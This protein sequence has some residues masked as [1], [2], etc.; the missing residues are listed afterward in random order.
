MSVWLFQPVK[1]ASVFCCIVILTWKLNTYKCQY[2]TAHIVQIPPP[3][4][5]F[6]AKYVGV[7][8]EW[9]CCQTR[10]RKFLPQCV[11]KTLERSNKYPNRTFTID[12]IL[13]IDSHL[14]Q[15]PVIFQIVSTMAFKGS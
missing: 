12:V 2:N 15:A 13:L 1:E 6:Q 10:L 9:M 4:C 8:C 11:S 3:I 7:E 14:S 5:C